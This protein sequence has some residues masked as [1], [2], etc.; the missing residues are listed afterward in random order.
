MYKMLQKDLD[1]LN[2]GK[3]IASM[4]FFVEVV[5]LKESKPAEP[6]EENDAQPQPPI[7]SKPSVTWEDIN[8]KNKKDS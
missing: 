5:E 6:Q 4:P 8:E 1:H 2:A 3:D 7:T